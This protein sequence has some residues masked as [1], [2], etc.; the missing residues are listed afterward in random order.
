MQ[1]ACAIL[2]FGASLDIQN[3]ST[4]CL[5]RQDIRKKVFEYDILFRISLQ[6]LSE[7]F[8]FLRELSEIYTGVNIK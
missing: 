3:F 6:R 5:T 7:S 2:S 4:L 8:L 1:C